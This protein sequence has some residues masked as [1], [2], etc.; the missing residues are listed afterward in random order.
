MRLSE[1]LLAALVSEDL[2]VLWVLR[3]LDIKIM[4]PALMVSS[5]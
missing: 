1:R 5:R 2:R 4:L 3:R